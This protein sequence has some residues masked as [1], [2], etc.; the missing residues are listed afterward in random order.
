M[1]GNY[2]LIIRHEVAEVDAYSVGRSIY[3]CLFNASSALTGGGLSEGML[4]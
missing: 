4:L 1:R 3:S 2:S